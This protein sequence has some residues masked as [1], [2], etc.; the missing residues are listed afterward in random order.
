MNGLKVLLVDDE[1]EFVT[2]LAERLELRDFQVRTAA[3]GER[4]L[5]LAREERP[6]LVVLDLRMPGI[7]G[8]EVLTRLRE[9]FPT[10]PIIL[11][12]GLGSNAEVLECTEGG[13]FACMI[14]PV[15]ID[16]LLAK[17]AAAVAAVDD[18]GE[19]P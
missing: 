4:A 6:D 19:Q 12:T 7:G 11:L 3:S 18:G 16:A 14:K 17:I 5:E 8:A 15:D 2:A 10:L 9:L 1:V 13:A